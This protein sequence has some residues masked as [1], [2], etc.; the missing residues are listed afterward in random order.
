MNADHGFVHQN[1][2][3]ARLFSGEFGQVSQVGNEFSDSELGLG[4]LENLEGEVVSLNGQTY[5][6]PV[7]GV[8]Q[9]LTEDQGLAFAI[10]A[11]G[12]THHHLDLPQGTLTAEDLRGLI[13]ALIIEHHENPDIIVAT[14]K[15]HATF[16]RVLLRTVS[17][18]QSPV[19]DLNSVIAHEKR[20][21]FMNWTGTLVGFRF[22]DNHNAHAD[23]AVE[24]VDGQ[25]I[26][27][28]HLHGI[29]DAR[30]SGGHLHE[31]E[32][33]HLEMHP[34]QLTVTLDELH[35]IEALN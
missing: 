14:I 16:A 29:S 25:I 3:A 11:R 13:D 28:L 1:T 19:E 15:L 18:P 17:A 23:P 33:A 12:G 24:A 6:V 22:P 35:T 7:H 2:S 20:F 8:P 10:S 9:L 31:F 30:D 5:A 26:S 4:V 21:E 32:L 27:G 34:V